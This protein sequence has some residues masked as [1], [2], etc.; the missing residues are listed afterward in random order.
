MKKKTLISL[1]VLIIILEIISAF[2]SA[3]EF[4]FRLFTYYTQYSNVLTLISSLLLVIGLFKNKIPK[5][6]KFFRYIT[7]NMMIITFFVVAL[8][9][10]PMLVYSIGIKGFMMFTYRSMLFNH[11][12]CPILLL[13]SYVFFERWNPITR[14]DSLYVLIPTLTYGI[15][16]IIL[17]LLRI[18]EGPYPFFKVYE[19]SICMISICVIGIIILSHLVSLIIFK[20]SKYNLK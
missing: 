18:V 6:L 20:I 2:M 14:K 7:V 13:I 1:N 10:V 9:L 12:I 19:Q 17:N 8:I 11:L 15:T 16:M 5:W 3:K 4:S